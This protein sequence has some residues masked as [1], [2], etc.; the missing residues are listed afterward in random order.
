M[1]DTQTAEIVDALDDL[2]LAMR[3]QR[4]GY[5]PGM[6]VTLARLQREHAPGPVRSVPAEEAGAAEWCERLRLLAS[7][8]AVGAAEAVGR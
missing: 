1:C 5:W 8:A 4:L 6:R 2:E 7:V 3:M